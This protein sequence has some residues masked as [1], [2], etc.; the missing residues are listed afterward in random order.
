MAIFRESGR[1]SYKPS[2]DTDLTEIRIRP[3]T[4]TMNAPGLACAVVIKEI[5]AGRS[6]DSVEVRA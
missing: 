3:E 5:A 4:S 6:I 2:R 1:R